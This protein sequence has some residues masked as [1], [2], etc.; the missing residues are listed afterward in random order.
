MYTENDILEETLALAENGYDQA[1]RFLRSA[2]EEEPT[3]CGPQ[4]FYFLSCLASGTG[5]PEKALEWLQTA[6]C[7]NGWW[8]RPEVLED[9]DLVPIQKCAAFAALKAISDAR[10]QEAL[11]QTRAVFSWKEKNADNL[12]IAVHGNTQNGQTAREDWQSLL[13]G[14][15]AWQLETIQSA[16]PDGYGSYRWSYDRLSYLPVANALE[17]MQKEGYQTL[18]CGG[19]S[20]GCDM[21]LRTIAFSSARCDIL[22][23]QSPY[24]PMLA[25]HTKELTRA[26]QKKH[27]ELR[28]RCGSA[29]VDCLPMAKQLAKTAKAAGIHA[30]LTIDEGCRHRFPSDKNI[31]I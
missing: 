22:L 1:Y 29:D 10:Y 6:I 3:R 19:F 7:T 2:Y 23:L 27:I 31:E 8:Y 13:Q 26:M 24:I 25:A 17:A 9:T 20:A 11:A 15:P 18:A 14:N 28:I 21:L 12:L 30:A 4:T 16:E 5:A